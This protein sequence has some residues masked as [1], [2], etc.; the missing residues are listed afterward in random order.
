MCFTIPKCVSK[1]MRMPLFH[2]LHSV[3]IIWLNTHCIHLFNYRT[4]QQKY[5]QLK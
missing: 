4:L 3:L 2:Y 5:G 1:M